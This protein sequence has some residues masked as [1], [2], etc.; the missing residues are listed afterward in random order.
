VVPA[1]SN[2]PDDPARAGSGVPTSGEPIG[3]SIYEASKLN[4]EAS[5]TDFDAPN[6]DFEASETDF[7]APNPDFEASNPGSDASA[8]THGVP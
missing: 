1:A 2:L 5:E 6:P 4:F 3:T 7:D 8:A